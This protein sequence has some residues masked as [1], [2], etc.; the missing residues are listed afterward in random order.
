MPWEKKNRPRK[1][2]RKIGSAKRK[3]RKKN[4][5]QKW[6]N[7]G[8]NMP[9]F[10]YIPVSYYLMFIWEKSHETNTRKIKADY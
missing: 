1:G 4:K 9:V 6:R 8:W 2:R 3:A 10:S 7:T 5:K